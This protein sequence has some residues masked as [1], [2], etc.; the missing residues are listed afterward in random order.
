MLY[1]RPRNF[2]WTHHGIKD[3]AAN[4]RCPRRAPECRERLGTDPFQVTVRRLLLRSF[5]GDCPMERN[6]RQGTT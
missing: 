4:L 1:S 5:C 6:D 3:Y 2:T